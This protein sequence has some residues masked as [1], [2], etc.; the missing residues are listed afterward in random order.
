VKI[1]INILNFP[2]SKVSAGCNTRF[3]DETHDPGKGLRDEPEHCDF[4]NTHFQ[5]TVTHYTHKICSRMW[6][7]F[8]LDEKFEVFM[9]VK[10]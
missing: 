10:I 8:C 1:L 9:V 4:N 5:E 7:I 2:E 6:D 3:L